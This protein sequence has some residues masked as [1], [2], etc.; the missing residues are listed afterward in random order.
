MPC[1]GAEPNKQEERLLSWQQ[2][3]QWK[4]TDSVYYSSLNFLFLFTKVFLLLLSGEF[5]AAL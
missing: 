1:D 4:A 3:S 2:L 5:S